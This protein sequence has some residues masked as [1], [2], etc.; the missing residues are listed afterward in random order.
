MVNIPNHV[1]LLPQLI[2]YQVSPHLAYYMPTKLPTKWFVHI[3]AILT[4]SMVMCLERA[5]FPLLPAILVVR[6]RP[7]PV[8]HALLPLRAPPQPWW[9]AVR[10]FRV[11]SVTVW[12]CAPQVRPR[13]EKCARALTEWSC[14]PRVRVRTEIFARCSCQLCPRYAGIVSWMFARVQQCLAAP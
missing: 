12:S 7:T 3:T 2:P 10:I 5:P 9:H 4:K 6:C 14:A 11:C 13:A 8:R 1:G